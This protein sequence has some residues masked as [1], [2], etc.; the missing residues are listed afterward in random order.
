MNLKDNRFQWP[1]IKEIPKSTSPLELVMKGAS[2]NNFRNRGWEGE[3]GGGGGGGG[4]ER[5]APVVF[6]EQSNEK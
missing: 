6:P 2:T 4:G 1:L 3:G 5:R